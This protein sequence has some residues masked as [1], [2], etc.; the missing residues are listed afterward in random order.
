MW[1]EQGLD[2]QS[3]AGRWE[4]AMRAMALE[5]RLSGQMRALQSDPPGSATKCEG[6]VRLGTME[7]V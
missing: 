1:S 2:G 4:A 3:I 5:A 6:A 7:V